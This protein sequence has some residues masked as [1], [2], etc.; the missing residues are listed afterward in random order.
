MAGIADHGA[1]RSGVT[2]APAAAGAMK[3]RMRRSDG[4]LTRARVLD[5]A[6]ECILER[7]Y[8]QASSNA[9]ARRA[10]VTWGTIQ[11]QFG[12]REALLLEAMIDRWHR[13]QD[14]LRAATVTGETLDARLLSVLDLLA[15]WYGAPEY[16][17]Y[18]QIFLDLSSNPATSEATRDAVMEHGR[19]LPRAW[20]PLF[21]QAMGQAAS[22]RELVEYAFLTLRGFLT[23]NTLS[24]GYTTAARDER[25]RTLLVR[26]VAAAI[27]E[28]ARQRG[29]SVG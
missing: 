21:A 7:G 24:A 3:G 9:I 6:I 15:G 17:A 23:A 8:Y 22:D 19:E 20:R 5:A 4:Q 26:G 10:G 13:L 29:L 1:A 12:S 14:G 11:H 16:L 25:F 28:R 18:M 2:S 27:T